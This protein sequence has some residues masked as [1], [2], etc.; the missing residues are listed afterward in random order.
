M[1][2]K[3][4]PSAIN[5]YL[6]CPHCFWLRYK[7][8]I[9]RPTDGMF[10]S[11]PGSLDMLIKLRFDYCRERGKL[12]EELSELRK[13]KEGKRSNESEEK[14]SEEAHSET[15]ARTD[16]STS[17]F[18]LFPHKETLEAWRDYKRGIS[19]TDEEGNVLYGAIDDLLVK[20]SQLFI[21]DY[22]TK[23]DD[24]I[25]IYES[26][27]TQLSLYALILSKN[28]LNVANTGFLLFYYPT[29]LDKEGNVKFKA[30]LQEVDLDIKKAERLYR[31]ALDVLKRD[32]PPKP[33][34]YCRF[35]SWRKQTIEF[36]LD[37]K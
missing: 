16:M 21:L 33:S 28:G 22:K 14:H 18:K 13:N 34:P 29:T 37:E 30:S 4:S 11:L 6:D 27:K 19:W 5:L 10:P 23:G 36:V 31:E 24:N 25:R 35:C 20:D 17:E 1:A 8:G 7:K 2:F 3:L 32:T 15:I 9:K 26:Y 12:P